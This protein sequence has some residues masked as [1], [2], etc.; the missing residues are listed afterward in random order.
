MSIEHATYILN[1]SDSTLDL[2]EKEIQ[3]VIETKSIS[4]DL[5]N[6]IRRFLSDTRTALDYIAFEIFTTY[7]RE[8][9]PTR[10]LK[11]IESKIYFP[12]YFDNSVFT[13]DVNERFVRLQ[14]N[15]YDI[16][17]LFYDEQPKNSD[18]KWLKHIHALSNHDKHRKFSPQTEVV[19]ERESIIL[20]GY[21]PFIDRPKS[22]NVQVIIE[23]SRFN[24][25]RIDY[26]SN[27]GE[28]TSNIKIIEHTI[29]TDL[30]FKSL[31][32]P[33]LAT[34]KNIQDKSLYV[35]NKINSLI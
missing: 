4:L 21:Y 19:E 12:I 28:K 15:N 18:N 14:E 20:G 6:S 25:E 3:S 7:C 24:G 26:N 1:S 8:H 27:S 33:V 16:Y 2:I 10:N 13:R 31:E 32:L 23:D 17:K 11:R 34:L 9:I 30:L 22:P 35:L 5:Q 29:W